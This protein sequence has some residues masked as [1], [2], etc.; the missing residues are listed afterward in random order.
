MRSE[1]LRYPDFRNECFH[2]VR[3]DFHNVLVY[4]CGSQI[5]PTKSE[6]VTDATSASETTDVSSLKIVDRSKYGAK[7]PNS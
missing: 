7:K 4:F 5:R 6:S 2:L 3:L 1:K